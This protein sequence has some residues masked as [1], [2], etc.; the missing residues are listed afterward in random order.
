MNT[1]ENKFMF[2]D[3]LSAIIKPFFGDYVFKILK[4]KQWSERNL[5]EVHRLL[6]N[7]IYLASS[8]SKKRLLLEALYRVL[9][10]EIVPEVAMTFNLSQRVRTA[11]WFAETI[12]IAKNVKN[13]ALQSYIDLFAKKLKKWKTTLSADQTWK[14]FASLS[15]ER[16]DCQDFFDKKEWLLFFNM[17]QKI[18]SISDIEKKI[19][20]YIVLF[21]KI[22]ELI[23]KKEL[24]KKNEKISD[25]IKDTQEKFNLPEPVLTDLTMDLRKEVRKI[26]NKRDQF[27]AQRL[28]ISIP[29][30]YTNNKS[31]KMKEFE[32][33]VANLK[34]KDKDKIILELTKED[35]NDLNEDD[36]SDSIFHL[37]YGKGVS[38][39]KDLLL[40]FEIPLSR[41]DIHFI[42]AGAIKLIKKHSDDI[43]YGE[44]EIKIEESVIEALQKSFLIK[45]IPLLLPGIAITE[46]ETKYALIALIDTSSSMWGKLNKIKSM[47]LYTIQKYKLKEIAVIGFGDSAFWIVKP[48]RD[49]YHAVARIKGIFTSGGTSISPSLKLLMKYPELINKGELII[50]T[51]GA[52][53]D[54]D[55]AYINFQKL[56]EIGLKKVILY[57]CETQKFIETLRNAG[58]DVIQIQA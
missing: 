17:F 21:Y 58:I 25:V 51:D 16:P 9:L 45:S 33:K 18:S 50:V 52:I 34:D 11:I 56:R 53:A 47:L 35:K 4:T 37:G 2:L 55:E 27:I 8:W 57:L 6:S 54:W 20:G 48:T 30:Q 15:L 40:D 38:V 1:A 13:R 19:M 5:V 10:N 39:G 22:L 41:K 12:K 24:E 32:E 42:E 28:L 44:P 26:I 46:T 31:I 3:L 49:I 36:E 14:V 43:W 7:K 23:A 29:Y